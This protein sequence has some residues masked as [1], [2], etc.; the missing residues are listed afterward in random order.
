MW[1]DLFVGIALVLIIEGIM[2]FLSPDRYRR[3]LM[4][5]SQ[6][7]EKT[8]RGVGFASMAAGLIVLYVVR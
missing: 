2:P 6:L 4:A 5:A 1:Q 8:V 3:I 7:N